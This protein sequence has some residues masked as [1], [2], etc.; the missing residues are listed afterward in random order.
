MKS[1]D[2]KDDSGSDSDSDSSDDEEW[3]ATGARHNRQIKSWI[4]YKY[5]SQV[6]TMKL[7]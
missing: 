2:K 7:E 6:I 3:M 5:L 1:D 4:A